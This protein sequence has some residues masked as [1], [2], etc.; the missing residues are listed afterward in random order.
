MAQCQNAIG[1][2]MVSVDIVPNRGPREGACM[3]LFYRKE[4]TQCIIVL[5]PFLELNLLQR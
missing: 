2:V 1:F 4:F 3:L 5:R